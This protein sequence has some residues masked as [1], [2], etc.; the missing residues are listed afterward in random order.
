M[1]IFQRRHYYKIGD[2][3]MEIHGHF[4]LADEVFEALVDDFTDMFV[5]DNSKFNIE[6]FHDYVG[7]NGY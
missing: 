3:L 4:G 6:M 7:V 2:L 1:S 5:K